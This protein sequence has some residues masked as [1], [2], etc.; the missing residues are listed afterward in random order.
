MCQLQE[1]TERGHLTTKSPA[2]PLNINLLNEYMKSLPE[3]V[4]LSVHT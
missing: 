3:V 2:A 1:V 4:N